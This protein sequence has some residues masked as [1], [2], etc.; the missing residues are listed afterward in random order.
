VT[1]AR[2]CETFLDLGVPKSFI[3]SGS[4]SEKPTSMKI[5]N[6]TA[7]FHGRCFRSHGLEAL[8]PAVSNGMNSI[9]TALADLG[10]A[11][12]WVIYPGTDRYVLD[13]KIT[14]VPAREI[15]KLVAGL[16]AGTEPPLP[17]A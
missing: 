17:R 1:Y 15:P 8:H 2:K 9:H 12:L 4:L 6:S 3:C 10:L 14:V 7:D 16:K 5:Q 11:H 13:D